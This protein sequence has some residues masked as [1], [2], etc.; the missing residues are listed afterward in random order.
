MSTVLRILFL[1]PIG[2]MLACCAAAFALL[3]P[4]L[5][6]GWATFTDPLQ[7]IQ[8][9]M[10]FTTM[11]AGIGWVA[12]VP[13]LIFLVLSEALRLRS[14][15]IHLLAG[16]VGGA[17]AAHAGPAVGDMRLQTATIVAGLAF[18]LTYWVLAGHRAGRPRRPSP[19]PI[20]VQPAKD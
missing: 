14:V 16:L 11:A 8:L 5:D 3:W 1:V 17:V 12:F 2:F 6:I 19:S 15:L 4:F 13:F 18:A 9:A 10:G 7:T 20:P